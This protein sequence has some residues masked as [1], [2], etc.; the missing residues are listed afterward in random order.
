MEPQPLAAPA[1]GTASTSTLAITSLV[2]GI[3]CWFALPVIGSLVAI[4]CGHMA[5]RD[6]R[7][8]RGALAGDGLAVGGLV[9]GYLHLATLVV[10]VL[11]AVAFFGGIAALLA[12]AGVAAS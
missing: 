7:A 2:F 8:A 6:I 4:A 3:V 11:L 5:R 10:A 1:T 9:L 12:F